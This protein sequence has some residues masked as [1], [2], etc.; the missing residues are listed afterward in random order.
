MVEREPDIE[1]TGSFLDEELDE[2]KSEEE[3]KGVAQEKTKDEEVS[4][5]ANNVL[6]ISTDEDTEESNSED[7]QHATR[8]TRKQFIGK[9][10][11]WKK[12][13]LHR[14]RRKQHIP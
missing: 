7:E 14:Q 6:Q 5:E 9:N 13:P 1:D 3:E 4:A 10:T 12:V 11:L 2:E 8:Y